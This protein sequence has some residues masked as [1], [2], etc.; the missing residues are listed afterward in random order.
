MKRFTETTKWGDSWFRKLPCKFKAFWVYLLDNCDLAGVWNA[1]LELASFQIGEPILWEEIEEIFK[2]RI[3]VLEN[4]RWHIT[5]FIPYQY[6]E[7]NPQNPCH[8]GVMKSLEANGISPFKAPS[9]PLVEGACN[10]PQDK[11]KDKE[12]DTGKAKVS[13]TK[14]DFQLRLEKLFNRRESTP[15]NDK[16]LKALKS[17]KRPDLAEELDLIETYYRLPTATEGQLSWRRTA[18]VTL[19]NNWTTDLDRARSWLSPKPSTPKIPD[20]PKPVAVAPLHEI[21]PCPTKP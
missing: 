21:F 8:K 14:T 7:L 18:L 5:K 15:W 10:G 19:L 13:E 20:A 1:D 3:I 11:D 6:G 4:G 2:G 16:E 17:L 9:K 12:T